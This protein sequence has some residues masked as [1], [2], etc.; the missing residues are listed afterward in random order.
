[1]EYI[2]HADDQNVKQRLRNR[3]APSDGNSNRSRDSSS[4]MKLQR[5]SHI[6]PPRIF[7]MMKNQKIKLILKL[8]FIL[9]FIIAK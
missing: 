7:Y 3:Q 4:Q 2:I 5:N 1:M 8:H 9:Y 6:I